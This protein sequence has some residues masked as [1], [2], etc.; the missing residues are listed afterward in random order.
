MIS[1]SSPKTQLGFY[2]TFEEQLSDSHPLDV[3]A[4][5]IGWKIF[6][7]AFSRLYSDEGHWQHRYVNGVLLILKYTRL[8]SGT[9]A[10]SQWA[11]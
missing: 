8:P 10:T 2:S 3:L 7:E 1:K 6:E 11:T 4:N 9:F 5:K